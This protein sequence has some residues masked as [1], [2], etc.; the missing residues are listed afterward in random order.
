MI[1]ISSRRMCRLILSIVS[2]LTFGVHTAQASETNIRVTDLAERTVTLSHPAKR[3]ILGESRYLFALSILNPDHPLDNIVGMLADLQSIDPGTYQQYQQRFPEIDDI[4]RVGHTSADSFSVEKVLSLNADLAIFGVEGH[5]PGARNA[6]LIDQL[7]RAGVT[8]VFIDF[9]NDPLINTVKSMRLLG[10]VLGKNARADAFIEYYQA[11][12]DRVV[13][14]LAIAM[15]KHSQHSP[16]VFLHS[17]VGLQDLCCETMARGMM[18]A[19]LDNVGGQNIAKERV[20][21]SAGILN[22]EYLLTEQPDIYI[23]TAIG[24]AQN[25]E[26]DAANQPPYIVLGAGVSRSDAQASFQRAIKESA[27]GSLTAVRNGHAY[28]IWHHFYNTPLNIAAVQVFAKWLYPQ[29]FADLD[30]HATLETL[31]QR[32]QPV[33]LNGTYWVEL[34]TKAG[35]S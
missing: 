13:K 15:A 29:T 19:F 25:L 3:I 8:V 7:E 32:F 16:A 24:A 30:P 34:D 10:D 27:L 31:Y 20:P 14:P 33:P 11:Q 18:A 6:Q 1:R 12:L 17:R 5:G 28:A 2:F 26:A 9:R 22:L 21:G 4:P 23:A 35:R